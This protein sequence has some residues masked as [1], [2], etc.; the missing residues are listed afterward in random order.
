MQYFLKLLLLSNIVIFGQSLWATP[1]VTMEEALASQNAVAMSPVDSTPANPLAPLISVSSPETLDIPVKNPF[2]IEVVMKAQKDSQL[3]F[4]S[5]KALYGAFKLDI[6]DRLLKEAA[7]TLNGL[8]LS[9][10]E[11]P[12]GKHKILLRISDNQGRIAEKELIIKVE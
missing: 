2:N 3:N 1:I 6:T 4:S 10:L 5:F 8:K 12:A 11:V 7:K 9:N